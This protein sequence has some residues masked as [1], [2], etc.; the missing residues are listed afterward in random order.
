MDFD[1]KDELLVSEWENYLPN[2]YHTVYKIRDN[3]LVEQNYVPL[4]RLSRNSQIDTVRQIIVLREHN[5]PDDIADLYFSK[6]T[7]PILKIEPPQLKTWSG[8]SIVEEYAKL[9]HH[10]FSLDSIYAYLNDS[11]Y[12]YRNIS[13]TSK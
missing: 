10:R 4:N 3:T 7:A 12:E 5:G 9:S 13:I 2:N 6:T 8:Q 11:V 1:G